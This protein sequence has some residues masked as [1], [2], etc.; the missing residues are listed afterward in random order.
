MTSTRDDSSSG[1]ATLPRYGYVPHEP[2]APPLRPRIRGRSLKLNILVHILWLALPLYF[3]GR[4]LTSDAYRSSVSLAKSSP[5][6]EK[7]LGTGI[8]TR[9]FPMGSALPSYGSDFAEWSVALEG[10]AGSGKLYGVA[11]RIGSAWEFSRLTF[12]PAK[13]GSIIDLTPAPSRLQLSPGRF[14]E[15]L[16]CSS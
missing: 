8:E 5:A 7:I 10:S 15:G 11:N 16:S 13:G 2:N 3:S 12:A 6:L 9:G 4:L 1:A 14:K